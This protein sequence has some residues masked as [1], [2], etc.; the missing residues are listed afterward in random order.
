MGKFEIS[1]NFSFS[2]GLDSGEFINLWQSSVDTAG[3][4]NYLMASGSTQN[5]NDPLQFAG[6]TLTNEFALYEQRVAGQGSQLTLRLDAYTN[7]SDEIFAFNN[8]QIHGQVAPASQ[9]PEPVGMASLTLVALAL[10]G[11]RRKV[12]DERSQ[13]LC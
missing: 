8:L 9:V 1:D 12:L 11:I 7:G 4:Q 6:M 10:A 13:C 5:Y 2:Y 3:S